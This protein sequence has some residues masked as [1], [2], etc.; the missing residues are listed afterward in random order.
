[1]AQIAERA[2]CSLVTLGKVEK[3]DAT[4]SIGIYL[5]VLYALRLD[6]DIL[7]LARDDELGR[8]VQDYQLLTRKR[9]TKTLKS[10]F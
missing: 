4:V 2:Q 8:H 9:A 5:R 1:M 7:F 3:G 10:E 6:E